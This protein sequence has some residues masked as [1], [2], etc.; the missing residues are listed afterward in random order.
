MFSLIKNRVKNTADFKRFLIAREFVLCT[1]MALFSMYICK[2]KNVDETMNF[3][4]P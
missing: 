1:K 2:L 3:K 4:E